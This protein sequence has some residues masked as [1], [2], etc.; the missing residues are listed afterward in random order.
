VG[1]GILL[2]LSPAVALAAAI[3]PAPANV[4]Y[5]ADGAVLSAQF[6]LPQ[7]RTT[8]DGLVE[9]SLTNAFSIEQAGQPVLPETVVAVVLP[10]DAHVTRCI[11]TPSDTMVMAVDGRVRHGRAAASYATG[12]GE[13]SVPDPMTYALD[14]PYPAI[15]DARW[16]VERRGRQRVANVHLTPVQYV[17]AAG[18]LLAHRR[19][20]VAVTW[21]FPGGGT[22]VAKSA[23]Q[24]QATV[25]PLTSGTPLATGQFDYVVITSTDLLQT[26]RPYNFQSLCVARN[27]D[28][29][30]ATNVTTDWIYANYSGTRPDGGTDNQTAIRNFIIDANQ[31]WGTRFVLLGG[32]ASRVPTRLMYGCVQMV[33]DSQTDLIASDMYYGCL[34][35][36]FDANGNGIYGESDDGEDGQDVDLVASVFVGRFPVTTTNEVANMVRKTL[37]YENATPEQ[38]RPISHMGEYLGLGGVSDYATAS[39]EQ[40]RLGGSYDGYAT[41]G[42]GSATN[43]ARFDISDCL[44]DA[45]DY[46]WPNTEV[47]NR[48]QQNFHVFN[49]LSHGAWDYCFKLNT[50]NPSDLNAMVGLTNTSYFLAYSQACEGGRFDNHPNCM[51]ETLV[52]ATNGPVAVIMNTRDGWG[53]TYATDG[54]SQH[55]HRHFWDELL[56]GNSYLLGEANQKSKEAVR[57]IVNNYGGAMRWCYYELTLFGDP[58]LPFGASISPLPPTI[59]FAPLPNQLATA[60]SYRVA[61]TFGPPGLYDPKT[62]QLIWRTSLAPDLVCTT[63]FTQVVGTSYEAFIPAISEGA[64][65]HYFIQVNSRAGLTTSAPGGAMEYSFCVTKGCALTVDGNPQTCGTVTPPYG[66]SQV[67]SG[68]TVCASASLQ[69]VLPDG[70]HAWQCIGWQGTGSVPAS[71]GSNVVS[72]VIDQPSTLVWRWMAQNSLSLHTSPDGLFASDIWCEAGVTASTVLAA[73]SLSSN[74]I[75]YRFAGWYLDNVRTPLTGRAANPIIDIDMTQPHD[76]MA[77]YLPESEDDDLDQTPDW[78]EM[79][80]Y[81]TMDYGP[82]DDTDGDGAGLLLEYLA[83]TDPTDSTSYPMPPAITVIPLDPV[84]TAP[85]P[86]RVYVTITDTSPLVSTQLVWQQNERAWQTN[87]L[88][89]VPAGT[90]LYMGTITTDTAAPGDRFTY[91]AQAVG[92]DGLSGQSVTFTTRLQYAAIALGPPISRTYITTPPGPVGDQLSIS[93]SGTA[94]LTWHAYAGFGEYADAPPSPNWNLNATWNQTTNAC[95]PWVWSTNRSCSGPASLRATITSPAPE[96]YH[97]QHACLT[98]PPLHLGAHAVLAFSHWICSEIDDTRAGYCWD[99]G[100]VEISTNG[101]V[102]FAQLSGPYTHQISGWLFSPWSDGTPC[103]AG[104]GDGWHDVSFDLS[105]YAGATAI[106]RFHYG[107]DDNGDR[108]GW[109]VDNIRV[110]PLDPAEVSGTAFAPVSDAVAPG[111]AEPLVAAVDTSQFNQRWLRVPV[112][113]QSSDPVTPNAWYD[114]QFDIRHAPV[115]SLAAAQA[116]NG[117]GIVTATGAFVDPDGEN[118]TLTFSCSGDDGATWWA[119]RLSS[120]TFDHGVATLNTNAGVIA[121]SIP[122]GEPLYVTNRFTLQWNTRDPSNN[123]QLA[124]R[125]LLRFTATDPS[126]ASSTVLAAPFP[127]DNQPPTTPALQLFT[128]QPQTWSASRRLTFNWDTSDGAGVGLLNTSVTLS[129]PGEGTNGAT[130]VY[131]T[132]PALLSLDCDVDSTN[133]WLTVQARDLMGNTATNTVGPF[134]IDATPPVA[135]ALCVATNEGRFGGYIVVS[136]VPLVGSN[137]TDALSGIAG[138]TFVNATRPDALPVSTSANRLDWSAIAW[139]VTNTFRVTATDRAGNSSAPAS[140]SVL[141]LDPL[142][143]TDGD[144]ISNVDEELIGTSPFAVNPPFAVTQ[145]AVV[146]GSGLAICWPSVAGSHYTVECSTQLVGGAWNAVPGLVNLAGTDGVMTAVVPV[147]AGTGFF[148]V[149]VSP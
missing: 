144:G 110:A 55:Y 123:V 67:A 86:Y 25:T 82:L 127:V 125:T 130:L 11:V 23:A 104:S 42:F 143:D 135:G 84:Q 129:R 21:T 56:G 136:C 64:F 107:A 31:N 122:F 69:E 7:L 33:N 99:G 105:A 50:L 141:V 15:G 115:L 119:P 63:Q 71:G 12:P 16:S 1:T 37:A 8:A 58:A 40:L 102:S 149:Q 36:T 100:V 147:D 118:R 6:D 140:I 87:S 75:N 45:P 108:E 27:Q 74:G 132:P 138:Y 148:R 92:R 79:Y 60:T 19:L 128:I 90:N 85:P 65:V 116:T 88:A 131:A 73:E 89:F 145:G 126:Y 109:Y 94:T 93:N 34:H 70:R 14:T 146:P 61:C 101:G 114:L 103:F 29:F 76:A 10:A 20:D 57:Y 139:G 59:G 52:T 26:P 113:I 17:P 30:A 120:V 121:H 24:S 66:S 22:A 137:F 83:G 54:P 2:F 112:L 53:A 13:P 35:G 77:L 96:A 39:M 133:W 91:W 3:A 106:L 9:L 47:I 28:G 49:D 134:W 124:M 51:A 111:A 18:I 72:F 38:L 95:F 48:F 98:T 80:Y 46:R 142:G 4:N 62:L 44:Y 5:S 68:N 78:W 32:D 81:G 117:S 41:V 97:S 43:A